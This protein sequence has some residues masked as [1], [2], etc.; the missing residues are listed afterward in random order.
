[1][2]G[3]KARVTVSVAVEPARAFSVFTE[4]IDSWWRHG[5]KFRL[6]GRSPGALAFEPRAGGRLFETYD[7]GDGPRVHEIG[8]ILVWEPPA[9]LVFEWRNAVFVPGEVTEVE[10]T[11]EPTRSGTRVTV[12]HRGWAAL[13][14]DHPARHGLPADAFVA[15][16]GQWWGD[17]MTSLRMHVR[18]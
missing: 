13:R 10:V 14:P 9:R 7:A 12:E 5:P 11:F 6:G 17:L 18:V 1:M 16:L 3:D 15:Q 4:E 8:K 2:R